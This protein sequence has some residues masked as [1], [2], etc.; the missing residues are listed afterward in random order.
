MTVA[1][2][3]HLGAPRIL[4]GRGDV[5]D[6][7]RFAVCPLSPEVVR[8]EGG[9]L[10]STQG[11]APD[12]AIC[13]E[14]RTMSVDLFPIDW[15]NIAALLLDLLLHL[16]LRTGGERANRVGCRR[17]TL[18]DIGTRLCFVGRQ[19]G[20]HR[21]NLLLEQCDVE[22]GQGH[23]IV[24]IVCADAIALDDALSQDG[25]RVVRLLDGTFA[26]R[27]VLS[28]ASFAEP[29]CGKDAGGAKLAHL[30]TVGLPRP[31]QDVG[32]LGVLQLIFEHR[33]KRP[34]HV[35]LGL[36]QCA[37]S[38]RSVARK[39][40]DLIEVGRRDKGRPGGGGGLGCGMQLVGAGINE[41]DTETNETTRITRLF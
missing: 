39:M 40:H 16:F 36:G 38:E 26:V 29:A 4:H 34:G 32:V 31:A 19:H 21:A 35:G 5:A 37:G 41:E 2:G 7:Q 20:S 25:I 6:E 3:E 27:A 10:E 24:Y 28:A 9:C 11:H 15:R 18:L 8:V 14:T 13:L 23:E 22:P 12:D 1:G 33:Q 17:G 30:A